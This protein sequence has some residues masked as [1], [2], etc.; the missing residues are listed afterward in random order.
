[1]CVCVCVHAR[2]HAR[3]LANADPSHL[4]RLGS[5]L[6]RL[7]EI[8]RPILYMHVCVFMCI[9]VCVILWCNIWVM[10]VRSGK[11][12]RGPPVLTS[13]SEGRIIINI[14]SAFKSLQLW[15][16]LG[17]ENIDWSSVPPSFLVPGKNIFIINSNQRP[18]RARQWLCF[19]AKAADYS[20]RK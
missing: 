14:T 9:C 19:C 5:T 7:E 20:D 13:P 15:R 17:T 1:M 16:E 10:N 4:R 11:E 18:L 6:L 2:T 8:V 12:P 3:A